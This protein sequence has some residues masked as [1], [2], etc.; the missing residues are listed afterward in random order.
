MQV[1]GTRKIR[2]KI[3]NRIWGIKKNPKKK[4]N[5]KIHRMLGMQTLFEKRKKKKMNEK[6]VAIYESLHLFEREIN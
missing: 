4:K 3:I 5:H 2:I 1:Q 6:C